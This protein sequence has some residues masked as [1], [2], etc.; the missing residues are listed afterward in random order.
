MGK[1]VGLVINRSRVQILLEATLRNNLGQ[2]C[3]HLCA[4]VTNQYNL[5]PAKGR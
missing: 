1:G 3:S 5:V 2:S 4:S